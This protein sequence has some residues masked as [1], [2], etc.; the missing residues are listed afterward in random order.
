MKQISKGPGKKAQPAKQSPKK[1]TANNAMQAWHYLLPMGLLLIITWFLY[2]PA[3]NHGFTNWDDPTYVLENPRVKNLNNENIGYF[4]SNPS[5]SNYHPFTM[6][7]LGIDYYYATRDNIGAEKAKGPVAARFHMTNIVLHLF[8]VLLVFIFVFLLSR[9]RVWVASITALLFAIHPMHVESVAWIAER[10]D[11]LYTFF[12]MAGLIGYLRYLERKSMLLLL[13]TFMLFICSLFSKPSAVVFP[14]ILLA[15][16]YFNGRKFSTS[17]WVEKIPFFALSIVFGLITVLIQSKDAIADIKVFTMVQ[18]LMFATY[19]FVMYLFKLLVPWNFSAFYPYPQLT[20]SGGLP[21][22]FYLSPLIAIIL[23]GLVFLSVRYTRVFVFGFLFYLFSLLLVLQFISVG[24]AIMADRYSYIA[25]IGVFFIIGWYV[26]RGF[27]SKENLLHQVRWLLAGVLVLFSVMIC[28][29]AYDQVKVWENSETLWTDVISKYPQAEVSYKNRGNYYGALNITDKALND[30]KVYV[31]LKPDDPRAFSNIGNIYGLRNEIDKALDSYS[32]SIALD[33][34]NPET[35]LNR[36]ITY[37]K[38]R[39][40]DL[41]VKDYEKALVL[42]PGTIEV[43]MNKAYTL[44]E[45]GRY[46]DAIKDYTFLIDQIPG[47]DDYF[48]KR[49]TC[50]YMLKRNQEALADYSRCLALNP[51]NGAACYNSSVLYSNQNDFVKAYQYALKAKSVNYPVEPSYLE[52]L[53]N[54]K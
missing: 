26:D 8:N 32:K 6:I 17:L 41:A 35:Y 38:A 33:S 54:K 37:A 11:V 10:K 9:K 27:T 29:V 47:N 48:L 15:I 3:I 22:I 28:K 53:K 30:Y 19:G 20:P 45:M 21:A 14:L 4:F 49:G 7:S 51:S 43:Y 46:E 44:L 13:V 52:G 50:Q 36:A 2:R 42:K 25:S 12:F 1:K 5:A 31:K 18:R 39:Q 40:F 16:D 24:S 34:V 23:G